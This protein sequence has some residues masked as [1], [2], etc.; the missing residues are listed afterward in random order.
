MTLSF[1]YF[2]SGTCILSS[3]G[4][5]S[6]HNI[7]IT[8][9]KDEEMLVLGQCYDEHPRISLSAINTGSDISLILND[10]L[11]SLNI[12]SFKSGGALYNFTS[13]LPIERNFEFTSLGTKW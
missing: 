13:I 7:S 9:D 10:E 4:V 8:L 6:S 5:I 3:N 2:S 11:D 12:T 1:S